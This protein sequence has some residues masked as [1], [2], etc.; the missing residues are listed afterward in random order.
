M[1][2][3]FLKTA[4]RSLFRYKN[5]SIFNVMGLAA[6]IILIAA[7]LGWIAV[8][9]FGAGMTALAAMVAASLVAY[10]A[11]CAVAMIAGSV[12]QRDKA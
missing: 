3:N 2:Y 9:Y 6:G 4:T 11:L 12:W 5:Y 8:G 10:A 7:G 1:L